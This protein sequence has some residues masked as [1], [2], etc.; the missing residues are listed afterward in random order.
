MSAID[1]RRGGLGLMWV[2]ELALEISD[3]SEGSSQI[4]RLPTPA[5]EREEARYNWLLAS[6]VADSAGRGEMVGGAVEKG[7]ER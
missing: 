2:R 3:C 6:D 5:T 1:R 7:I 4:L